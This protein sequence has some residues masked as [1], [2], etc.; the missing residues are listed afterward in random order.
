ME[1]PKKINEYFLHKHEGVGFAAVEYSKHPS[2]NKF[3]DPDGIPSGSKIFDSKNI[4]YEC[5][6]K[7]IKEVEN[8]M[9]LKLE[10]SKQI[11]NDFKGKFIRRFD[12][13][14][15][16]I[17]GIKKRTFLLKMTH[18]F[19]IVDFEENIKTIAIIYMGY[20]EEMATIIKTLDQLLDV[21]HVE[22]FIA[23]GNEFDSRNLIFNKIV[24]LYAHKNDSLNFGAL[25]NNLDQ[26][27]VMLK[28]R[29]N[30]YRENL[31]L[32]FFI[33]HD[34]RDKEE[35]AKPLYQELTKLGF[36]VWYDEYSLE[37]GDSLTESIEKGISSSKYGILILS[38]N[39]LSNEKWAKNE[40]QSLKTKQIVKN[41]NIILPIWHM[42]NETDLENNYWLLDKVAGNT[43]EGLNDL[44]KRLGNKINS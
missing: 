33:S 5:Y 12:L 38:K 41:K 44:A 6:G 4:L 11:E 21:D 18:S 30:I 27:G 32:D 35:V 14:S 20:D 26:R 34:S 25:K 8:T 22:D 15:K 10:L 23:T 37:I 36:K 40:L 2:F 42:I 39:F 3:I 9:F 24:F 31:N 29:D 28:I 13:D 17:N 16:L 19:G 43:N 7:S 1:L